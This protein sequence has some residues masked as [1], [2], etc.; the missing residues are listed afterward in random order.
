MWVFSRLLA[1]IVGL[2]PAR[3]IDAYLLCFFLSGGGLSTG[4]ITRPEEIYQLWF[5]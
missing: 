4:L 3:C 1:G 2:N 5:A